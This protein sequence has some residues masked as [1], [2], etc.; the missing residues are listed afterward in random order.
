[1]GRE[2]T[3]C[4]LLS[5]SFSPRSSY[6]IVICEEYSSPFTLLKVQLIFQEL[7]VAL[8]ALVNGSNWWREKRK[9]ETYEI[10]KYFVNTKKVTFSWV[11]VCFNSCC[12]LMCL[13][14]KKFTSG[15]SRSR[16]CL[17]AKQNN[18]ENCPGFS[19]TASSWQLCPNISWCTDKTKNTCDGSQGVKK[20][21]HTALSA[22]IK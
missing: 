22:E 15:F 10:C 12:S 11:K 21:H 5:V 7:T 20:Y 2:V 14:M 8:D 9:M 3:C 16:A 19:F 6:F 17:K 13:Y 18:L 1:M 4:K